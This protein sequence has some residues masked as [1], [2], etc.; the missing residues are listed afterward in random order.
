MGTDAAG[1][2]GAS[3][4]GE[5]VGFVDLQV[6]G[7]L[8]NDF[9]AP[10]LTLEA[11]RRAARYV[12]AGG[13]AAFLPTLV[14]S[15]LATYRQNLPLLA[16]LAE[17]PEFVGRVAG[18]H[19]EG[20][21]L[22]RD[23]RVLGVHRPE[24]VRAAEPGLLEEWQSLARGRLRLITLAAEIDGAAE[25][26]RVARAQGIAVAIGHSWPDA[27]ALE[28]VHAAGAAALTH[29]GNGVPLA[30]P[31]HANPLVAGLLAQG[32]AAMLITDGHHV[33]A[34]FARL[35]RRVKGA[36]GLL[37]TSDLSPAAGL[38]PGQHRVFGATVEVSP[39]GAIRDPAHGHLAGS[40]MSLLGCANQAL[41]WG[42]LTQDEVVTAARDAPAAL[43]GLDV[44]GLRA[45]V[46][47]CTVSFRRGAAPNGAFEL[48]TAKT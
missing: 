38:A 36:R 23:P 10:D 44:A 7:A 41:A 8:G 33:T 39:D 27:A 37:L 43:I 45:P 21:F 35:V 6:N 15:P 40:S 30:L 32:L 24:H 17:E 28:C 13:T 25:L 19:L 29:F 31:R 34:D 47:G 26:T 1:A 11:A 42:L 12:L 20:P 14:S 4:I 18:I 2:A 46:D 22:S 48:T 9:S 3:A 16:A 5:L